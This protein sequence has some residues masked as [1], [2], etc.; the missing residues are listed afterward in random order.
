M[1]KHKAFDPAIEKARLL[2]VPD[3]AKQLTVSERFLWDL[4]RSGQ[5]LHVRLGRLVR[6]RPEDLETFLAD[7][8]TGGR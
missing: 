6:L 7:R 4:I 5:L 1:S 2:T 3:A 8:A